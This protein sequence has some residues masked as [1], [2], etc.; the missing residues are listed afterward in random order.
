MVHLYVIFI[1]IVDRWRMPSD[2]VL[3]ILECEHLE[4]VKIVSQNTNNKADNIYLQY[5]IE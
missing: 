5:E 1:F 3:N 4:H 2:P